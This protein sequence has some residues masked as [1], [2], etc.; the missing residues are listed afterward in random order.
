[1]QG[2]LLFTRHPSIFMVREFR[3]YQ[4]EGKTNT[5]FAKESAL[6]QIFR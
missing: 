1:L 6:M 4:T 3:P 5:E 2:Y